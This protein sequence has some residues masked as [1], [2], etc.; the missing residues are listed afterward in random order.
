MKYIKLYYPVVIL[1]SLVACK[2]NKE[3][4]I[5]TFHHKKENNTK[6][7]NQITADEANFTYMFFNATK[8]KILGN[9]EVAAA[10]YQKCIDLNPREGAPYYELGMIYDYAKQPKLAIEYSKKA[11]DLDAEN[12][13]YRYM[14]AQ[15]LAKNGELDAALK[16]YE[17]LSSKFPEDV[18]VLFDIA[19]LYLYKGEY[20]KAIDAYNKVEK[21]F[22]INEEISF[23]KQKAYIKLGDV[24]KA[25]TEIKKLIEAYPEE[26]RYYGVLGDLYM[27]N[28]MYDKAYETFQKVLEK[29]PDEPYIHLSLSDYYR[30]IGDEAKAFEELKIAFHSKSLTIDNK[31]SILLTFYDASMRDS[32]IK[33]QAYELATIL[34]E[35]HPN[36][37]KSYTIYADLLYRDKKLEDAYKNYLKAVK[38]DNSRIAIWNQL[39][40]ISGELQ[41][42]NAMDSLSNAALEFFPNQ[43]LLYFF[44]GTAKLQ[45]KEYQAAIDILLSGKDF[46]IDNNPLLTQFY[47]N[48]GEAYYRIKDYKNSDLYFDKALKIEPNNVLVLN[49]YSYY[50]SLRGEKLELA[51]EMSNLSN[52]LEPNQPNY[53]DTYGWILYKQKKYD[54]ALEWLL[55]A[56]NNGG[57][58]NSVILEHIGDTYFQLNQIEKAMEFWQKAMKGKGEKSEF[59]SKKIRDKT[60]YE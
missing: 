20:L 41:D 6:Y 28:N 46:V 3:T 7:P 25:A 16:Q 53:Q 35:A 9:Y 57:K 43:A 12:Y 56:Y 34:M 30:E 15:S 39:L 55:K 37:A 38:L 11:V 27:A 29:D 58:N 18:D 14:Y 32:V 50:L 54:E 17:I 45:K 22:G 51:A 10:L 13:W 24:E 21:K 48:L 31:M 40:F 5:A 2:A 60:L 26:I 33:K 59:L 23:Q 42:Y 36:E 47:A 8:E 19:N 49:N 52:K 1:L 44:N 4:S